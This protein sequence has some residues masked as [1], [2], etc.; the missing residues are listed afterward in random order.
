MTWFIIQCFLYNII[1]FYFL[2]FSKHKTKLLNNASVLKRR[3]VLITKYAVFLN[4]CIFQNTSFFCEHRRPNAINQPCCHQTAIWGTKHV[5]TPE[6]ICRIYLLVS[7]YCIEKYCVPLTYA[8]TFL[9]ACING[10]IKL[11][12]DNLLFWLAFGE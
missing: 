7:C 6:L 5:F 2:F 4:T 11:S 3:L 8:V 12:R 9:N 1:A 10:E